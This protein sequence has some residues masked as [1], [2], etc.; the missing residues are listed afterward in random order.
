M[1]MS[2]HQLSLIILTFMT[3]LLNLAAYIFQKFTKQVWV[4]VRALYILC[5]IMLY[6]SKC[7][8]NFGPVVVKLNM[9]LAVTHVTF[10]C[11]TWTAAWTWSLQDVQFCWASCWPLTSDINS[12]FD[13]R[14]CCPVNSLLTVQPTNHKPVLLACNLTIPVTRHTSNL[15][16]H[17]CSISERKYILV[18]WAVY[19]MYLLHRH[20]YSW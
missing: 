15:L 10:N 8:S 13:C 3:S 19:G 20:G 17:I 18:D 7:G 11:H 5:S 6:S 9:T 16:T 4:R 14:K 1:D 12:Q 2:N